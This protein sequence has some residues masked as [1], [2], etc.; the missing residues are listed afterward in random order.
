MPTTSNVLCS[1]GVFMRVKQNGVIV[2]ELLEDG[3]PYKLWSADLYE[4]PNCAANIITGFANNPLAFNW[5]KEYA[6]L[7]Q[8]AETRT[9]YPG[10]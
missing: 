2:E 1:C 3:S 9:I 8:Q 5:Q 7:K 6:Q 10:N 4:C